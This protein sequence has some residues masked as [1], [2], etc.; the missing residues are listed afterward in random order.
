MAMTIPIPDLWSEKFS[1]AKQG[2]WIYYK[3]YA[4][5]ITG[6]VVEVDKKTNFMKVHCFETMN[7]RWFTRKNIGQYLVL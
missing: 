5:K 3:N 2:D 1:Q 7:L 4:S 6:L